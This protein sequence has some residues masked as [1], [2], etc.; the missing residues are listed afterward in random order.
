MPIGETAAAKEGER[1]IDFTSHQ[2]EDQDRAET[3]AADRPLLQVH[4]LTVPGAQ[5]QQEYRGDGDGYDDKGGGHLGARGTSR[6][7]GSIR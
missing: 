4:V 1:R 2:H 6:L 5:P 3:A 7:A